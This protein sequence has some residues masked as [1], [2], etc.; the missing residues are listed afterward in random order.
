MKKE[1][2]TM[3]LCVSIMLVVF[4]SGCTEEEK[5]KS[6]TVIMTGS[7]FAENYNQY[8]TN[9]GDGNP[10]FPEV[11]AKDTLN[12]ED[13]ISNISFDPLNNVTLITLN[14][15]ENSEW[16]ENGL[17]FIGNITNQYIIGENVVFT[18]HIVKVSAGGISGEVIDEI[19]GPGNTD[20]YNRI[21]PNIISKT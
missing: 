3:C 15:F 1:L 10:D 7:E 4:T 18:F 12:V 11:N 5:E 6:K 13:A 8:I 20:E 14:G 2:F 17:G 19:T 9:L 21:D 16:L